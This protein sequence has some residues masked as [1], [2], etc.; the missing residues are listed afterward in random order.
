MESDYRT[1]LDNLMEDVVAVLNYPEWPAAEMVIRIFSRL[2]KCTPLTR[3][4]AA[5]IT[6]I[7]DPKAD[8]TSKAMAIDYLGMIAGRLKKF[9]ALLDPAL[10][11]DRKD[12]D[13]QGQSPKEGGWFA[14][15][16][17]NLVRGEVTTSIDVNALTSLWR[18]QS[19]VL[20]FLER[21]AQHDPGLKCA[22]QLLLCEWGIAF[23]SALVPVDDDGGDDNVSLET[24]EKLRTIVKEYWTLSSG[25]RLDKRA[26]DD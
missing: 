22:H 23:A 14:K 8:N 26:V 1:I 16:R 6:N 10:G 11:D 7:D 4:H 12:A 18:C 21:G 13:A 3:H 20:E 24:K 17:K 9:A 5:Q 2:M 19:K 25:G 15:V